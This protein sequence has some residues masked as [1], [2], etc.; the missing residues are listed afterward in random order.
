MRAS[1]DA[2]ATLRTQKDALL[3]AQKELQAQL[4][5]EKRSLAKLAEEKT[6]VEKNAH[7]ASQTQLQLQHNLDA[8]QAQLKAAQERAQHLD[9]HLQTAQKDVKEK[10]LELTKE[11]ETLTSQLRT[12]T[13]ELEGVKRKASVD[14]Q[15]K[16]AALEK[17]RSEMDASS[18]EA[19]ETRSRL[20]KELSE[21]NEAFEELMSLKLGADKRVE[22]LSAQ[23]ATV[24]EEKE[25]LKNDFTF[26]E[27]SLKSA[28]DAAGAQV[29]EKDALATEAK[30]ELQKYEA[31]ASG[32]KA[33][34]EARLVELETKSGS[35][36]AA[37]SAELE[38]A[39]REKT[40]LEG[41]VE[42]LTES[43]GGVREELSESRAEA[44]S[45][46]SELASLRRAVEEGEER[47]GLWAEERKGLLSKVVELEEAVEEE[48]DRAENIARRVE[49]SV[50]ALQELGRE[51]Q[52]L[53]IGMNKHFNRRWAEDKDAVNCT[54][55][56]REFSITFRK[57]HCRSCGLIFCDPCTGHRA[58]TP[59]TRKPA[60]VCQNCHDELV[61]R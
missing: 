21:R 36:K 41:E 12:L 7:E 15:E 5:S 54:A 61:A 1:E 60:R 45:V 59:A 25:H 13:S 47:S 43:L 49:D 19:G 31:A 18:G 57:H 40:E 8:L 46:R 50:G 52:T 14:E 55:C 9:Q 29:R 4:D 17:L 23:L 58:P 48:R 53:Q 51:N 34:F 30:A 38:G 32:L 16:S 3:T 35:E 24:E 26:R 6:A 28:L 20:E 42:T 33:D 39:Q 11:R 22:G 27:N 2:T 44:E 56:G 37:M 10:E